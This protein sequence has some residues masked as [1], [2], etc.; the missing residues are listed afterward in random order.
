MGLLALGPSPVALE[1]AQTERDRKLMVL[2]GL[3][4]P[5]PF[6]G[7]GETALANGLQAALTATRMEAPA[8][9]AEV[10]LRLQ[11]RGHETGTSKDSKHIFNIICYY[12]LFNTS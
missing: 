6:H 5:S 1:K 11:T 8:S 2:T 7:R 9:R 4:W 10:A 12:I 3:V